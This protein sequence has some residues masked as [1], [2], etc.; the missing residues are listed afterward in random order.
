MHAAS[1]RSLGYGELA[2]AAVDAAGPPAVADLKLKDPKDYK[3]IGQPIKGV[4]TAAIVTGKP[5]FSIDFT[6]PGMLYAVFEKAPGIRGQGGDREPRRDQGD[7]RREA[8]LRRRRAAP[9][10]HP[11]LLGGVAIVADSWWQAN[12]AR[13]KLQVTWA[14]HPTA[15]AEQRRIRAQAKAFS[16][17]APADQPSQGRRRRRGVQDRRQGR[18]GRVLLPVHPARAARTAELRGACSRT[19]SSSSGRRA[20]RR[21]RASTLAA[22]HRADSAGGRHACT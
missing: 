11:G 3:I 10:L 16:T 18:R 1:K 6:L 17:Q 21:S 14:E 13:Q 12:T 9:N 4:D 15:D 19:A 20:R 22:T 8:R 5:I 2:A 7:A